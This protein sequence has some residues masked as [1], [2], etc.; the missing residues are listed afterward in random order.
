MQ[1]FELWLWL[2]SLVFIA[3]NIKFSTP[4]LCKFKTIQIKSGSLLSYTER[5]RV[6]LLKPLTSE[7]CTMCPLVSVPL[8]SCVA[9]LDAGSK[10]SSRK[11]TPYKQGTMFTAGRFL[12]IW[13][14]SGRCF[15]SSVVEAAVSIPCE[16]SLSQFVL[17]LLAFVVRLDLG[18][19]TN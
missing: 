7:K 6:T 15:T 5:Q 11:Q 12:E 9:I 2:F 18:S 1:N 10:Y 16:S 3:Q 8:C 4:Y 17:G 14:W 13:I 19:I